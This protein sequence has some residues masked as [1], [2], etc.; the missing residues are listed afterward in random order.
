MKTKA[1]KKIDSPIWD[2][3]KQKWWESFW[4]GVEAPWRPTKKEVKFWEGKIKEILK[5]RG[6][7]K[8]LLLGA[9]PEFRD[10]LTKYNNK[11]ETTLLDLNPTAKAAMDKLRK[12]KN[13]KEKIVWGDWLKMPLPNDYFDIV[14]NDEGFENI[15]IKNHNKL[16]QNIK[17]ILKPNGYF[18]VARICLEYY[19]KYPITLDSLL[20][21]YKKD[22][23]FFKNFQNRL[24][25]LY[26]LCSTDKI[27]YNKKQ[28]AVL[29]NEKAL[30]KIA[31]EA[32]KK[33]IKN[34]KYLRWDPRLDYLDL[35]YREINMFDLKEQKK[36]INKY[37]EIEEIYQDL[38]HPVMKMKYNFVLRPK[39]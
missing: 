30:R 33:G 6:K 9:T 35:D 12:T 16:H 13:S 3:K 1:K 22:I 23:S 34:L 26:S 7:I 32:S 20:R 21:K 15:D 37:F 31:K 2:I 25:Y 14:L 36:M 19:F 24:F 39:K 4:N 29:M 28:Q 11:A 17:R 10:M 27:F 5:K 8:V 18:L 38:F